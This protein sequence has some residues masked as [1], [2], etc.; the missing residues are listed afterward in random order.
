MKKILLIICTSF[1]ISSFVYIPAAKN[2]LVAYYPLNYGGRIAFD[3][4]YNNNGTLFA[5]SFYS[6]NSIYFDAVDDY[7]SIPHH[8]CH[9]ILDRFAIS[10]WAKRDGSQSSKYTVSKQTS[11]GGDNN[12][13]VLYGYGANSYSFYASVATGS[14]SYPSTHMVVNDD[15]WHNIVYT[16]NGSIL[17]GYV[18]GVQLLSYSATFTLKTTGTQALLLGSFNTTGNLFK[19]KIC[20]FKLYSSYLNQSYVISEYIAFKNNPR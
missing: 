14:M 11:G 5:G 8:S 2:T 15:Y 13:S 16:Y 6:N 7:V 12:W 4:I 17:Y 20:E 3:R 9:N 18:D 1:F 19:G 10:F